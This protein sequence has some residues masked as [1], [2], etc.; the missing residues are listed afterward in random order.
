[1]SHPLSELSMSDKNREELVRGIVRAT[2][3]LACLR[4]NLCYEDE[5][6]I[7][8]EQCAELVDDTFNALYGIDTCSEEPVKEILALYA[9]LP[10][11]GSWT[12]REHE[13]IDE[14]AKKLEI[15][16]LAVLRQGL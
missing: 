5:P 13:V 4:N 7:V 11:A 14:L 10:P 9:A 15:S 3:E 12:P 8:V 2:L 16:N 1:M 6:P